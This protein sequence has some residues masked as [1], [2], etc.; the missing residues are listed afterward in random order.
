MLAVWDNFRLAFGTFWG[1]PLRSFLTLVGIV[2]G[3]ATVVSMMALIEGLR[4]KVSTDLSDL[5][6]NCFQ[7]QKM[8][9][10][11]GRID[12]EKLSKRPHLTHED[13]AAIRTQPSI[14]MA[15]GEQSEGGQRLSTSE[16]ETSNNVNVWAGTPE[17]FHTNA[18]SVE[19]GR[20]FTD[21]EYMEAR[22]VVVVGQDVA[23]KLFPGVEPLGQ[24]LRIKG[25]PF[26]VVGVLKRRGASLGGGSMDNYVMIPLSV[27]SRMYGRNRSLFISIQA[28]STEVMQRAQDEVTLLMRRR[29]E[30][31]PHEEDDFAMFSNESSTEMF[32]NISRVISAAGFGVC[33]LSLVVGGI[34][35][36]NIMLVSVAE[37]TKE[38]GIRKA[39]GARKRRILAQF[40]TEAVALSLV[41]GGIGVGLGYA[42]A[43]FARW[44]LSLPT[45][46]PVW[47]VALSLA[48]SSV[49]GLAFGIYPA[50]RA[51]RLDP[52]EAM[53]VD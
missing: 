14:L 21:T 29:H 11:F 51:A 3:V 30:L 12:W 45:E 17:Y 36:L 13:L 28:R 27:F 25:R 37:R 41:G 10:G 50:A 24:E 43:F 47:A 26:Q 46:V 44:L 49:V 53:R 7:L 22:Q 33:L 39:L 34:G 15:A 6:V 40:A 32:N 52:V 48:M 1:N 16:R 42:L 23:D 2:I 4:I 9:R 35:I 19:W 18:I 31:K 38:I 8:P 5:G 20:A